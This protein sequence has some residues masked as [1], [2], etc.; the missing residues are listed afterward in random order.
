MVVSSRDSF[1]SKF[2]L[3]KKRLNP[4]PLVEI[5]LGLSAKYSKA[6][7]LMFVRFLDGKYQIITLDIIVAK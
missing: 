3:I 6:I 1:Q 4:L 2:I 7:D 5:D